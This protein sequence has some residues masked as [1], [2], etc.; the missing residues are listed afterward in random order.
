MLGDTHFYDGK[1]IH[2]GEKIH[3]YTVEEKKYKLDELSKLF[4]TRNTNL[5]IIIS[6][7][8]RASNFDQSNYINVEDLLC[9]IY[10]EYIISGNTEL[11]SELEIQLSDMSSGLCPQGRCTRVL[12][13]LFSFE[14]L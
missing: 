3:S 5:Q 6:D 13:I 10:D 1:L 2:L 8:N 14:I 12:Q 11:I 9:R 7:I 4:K